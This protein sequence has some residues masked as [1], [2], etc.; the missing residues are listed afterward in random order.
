M[1]SRVSGSLPADLDTA[2]TISRCGSAPADSEGRSPRGPRTLCSVR[3]RWL[4][5]L[6]GSAVGRDSRPWTAMA[7]ILVDAGDDLRLRPAPE[8][9]SALE[10]AAQSRDVSER[11]DTPGQQVNVGSYG[12][13][14]P[15]CDLRSGLDRSPL[16]PGHFGDHHNHP[17]GC[18]ARRMQQPRTKERSL[19]DLC[20]LSFS[21]S[22]GR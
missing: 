20:P 15:Y 4:H 3:I 14:A 18:H 17:P 21:P 8:T 9:W 10:Y 12:G 19:S 22:L 13:W 5:L 6:V 2:G 16:A 7:T 1:S 11:R